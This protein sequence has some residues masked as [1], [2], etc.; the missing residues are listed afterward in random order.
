MEIGYGYKLAA[1]AYGPAELVRQAVR[2]VEAGFDFVE[3]SDH[4]HPWLD[5]RGHSP[6]PRRGFRPS[7]DA[8][9][10]PGS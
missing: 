6:F 4:F 7:R 9:R 8:K 10:R 2:A 1:E 3:M 5:N